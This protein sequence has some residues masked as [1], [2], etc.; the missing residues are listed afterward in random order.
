MQMPK[1]AP[2]FDLVNIRTEK[3]IPDNI[4]DKKMLSLYI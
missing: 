1:D 4:L 3:M 2:A